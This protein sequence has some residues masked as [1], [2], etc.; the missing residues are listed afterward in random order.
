MGIPRQTSTIRDLLALVV[1]VGLGVFFAYLLK[2]GPGAMWLVVLLGPPA[3]ILIAPRRVLSGWQ[4]PI[5]AAVISAEFWDPYDH[6]ATARDRLVGAALMWAFLSV[7]SCPW[8][9]LFWRRLQASRLGKARDEAGAG[10]GRYAL[11]AALFIF[12]G[13]FVF[14][15][16]LAIHGPHGGGGIP[17]VGFVLG[18]MGIGFW[19]ASYSVASKLEEARK[20]A[21]RL[22]LVAL[23]FCSVPLFIAPVVLYDMR[24]HPS[25]TDAWVGLGDLELIATGA[26]GLVAFISL[27][28]LLVMVPQQP[29]TPPKQIGGIR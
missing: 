29:M 26:I 25:D 3:V 12:G 24:K 17:P 6:S 22:L 8:A 23:A 9:L 27:V 15:A 16:N 2:Y 18:L 11:A 21:R 13:V 14:K 5:L 7:F 28:W 4:L 20:T 1:G 10:A 19:W